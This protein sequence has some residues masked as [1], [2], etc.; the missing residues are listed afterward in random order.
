LP[1]TD[2]NLLVGVFYQLSFYNLSPTIPQTSHIELFTS[3]QIWYTLS[4]SQSSLKFN[5]KCQLFSKLSTTP[6]VRI[7]YSIIPPNFV[8]GS[9]M[10][11]MLCN[12]LVMT[13]LYSSLDGKIP[14]IYNLFISVSPGPSTV[15]GT[16]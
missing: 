9:F 10:E 4:H 6:L 11:V 13:H 7:N 15:P 14:K 16:R 1:P 12:L 2:S 8:Y 5:F 3:P